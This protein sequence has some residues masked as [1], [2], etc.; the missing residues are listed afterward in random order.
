MAQNTVLVE[1]EMIGR[2]ARHGR[3]TAGELA[4]ADGTQATVRLTTQSTNPTGIRLLTAQGLSDLRAGDFRFSRISYTG[5]YL[6]RFLLMCG[7]L[8]TLTLHQPKGTV[9]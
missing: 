9:L 6:A 8:S 2:K 4:S 1:E 3:V 5:R 7:S